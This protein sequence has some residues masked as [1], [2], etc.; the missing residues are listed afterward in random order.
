[1]LNSVAGGKKSVLGSDHVSNT[2]FSEAGL[3]SSLKCCS[4]RI[5]YIGGG[6]NS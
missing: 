4:F 5:L 6:Y 2:S 3:R 1:M